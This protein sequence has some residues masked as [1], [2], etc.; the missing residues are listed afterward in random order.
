MKCPKCGY[1]NKEG[2]EHCDMCKE[3]FPRQAVADASFSPP[4]TMKR[5]VQA[6]TYS[7]YKKQGTFS[8]ETAW[9]FGWDTMKENVWLFVGVFLATI[10]ILLIGNI[11]EKFVGKP[12]AGII[13][14][15]VAFINIILQMGIYNICLKLVDGNATEFADLFSCYQLGWKGFLASMLLGLAFILPIGVWIAILL[16]IFGK[17]AV[18]TIVFLSIIVFIPVIIFVTVRYSFILYLIIDK[19]YGPVDAFNG[20]YNITK[21]ASM[22][23]FSFFLL[24]GGINLLG[25]LCLL[26]GLFATMPATMIATA[27]VYRQLVTNAE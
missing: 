15:L 27:H 11:I 14:L 23:L 6:A 3:V 8:R 24:M 5:A 9:D 26:I 25:A 16:A 18:G 2:A 7:N 12:L 20:S 13:S 22:E 1:D 19:G 4:G 17:G 10:V 21:G